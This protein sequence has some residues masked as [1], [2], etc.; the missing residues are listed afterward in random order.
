MEN[1]FK[2][3]YDTLKDNLDSYEEEYDSFIDYGPDLYKLLC[4]C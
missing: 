2:D 3:F 1:D 4:S